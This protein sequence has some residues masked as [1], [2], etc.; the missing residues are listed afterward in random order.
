MTDDIKSRRLKEIIDL[1]QKISYMLN[2]QDIGKIFKV[3]VEGISKKNEKEIF[4]RNS[5]N[6]V[7]VFA[8]DLTQKGQFVDVEVTNCTCLL[9][10]SRCV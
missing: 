10:T 1:Q 4:G 5:Q 9:Y 8:G 6:K 7:I 2:K 3:L